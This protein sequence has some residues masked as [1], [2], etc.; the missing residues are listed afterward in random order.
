M[1]NFKCTKS[2]ITI[3]ESK[4]NHGV[5]KKFILNSQHIKIATVETDIGYIEDDEVNGNAVIFSKSYEILEVL[6]GLVTD[7]G[8]LLSENDIE[9]QSAGYFEEAKKL[10]SFFKNYR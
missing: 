1:K 10:L 5:G 9:W 2:E 7:L 6:D 4:P 3:T 8:A